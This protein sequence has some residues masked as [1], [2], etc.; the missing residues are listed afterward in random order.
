M[1]ILVVALKHRPFQKVA[2][3]QPILRIANSTDVS[4]LNTAASSYR[5]ISISQRLRSSASEWL[6]ES[7]SQ[8]PIR[9]T[10][11]SVTL[12]GAPVIELG[13][14]RPLPLSGVIAYGRK[15]HRKR[16]LVGLR[17]AGI[18]P[19]AQLRGVHLTAGPFMLQLLEYKARGGI[20]LDLHITMSAVRISPS[21]CLTSRLNT[22]SLY[23]QRAM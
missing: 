7:L 12:I 19:G 15:L 6:V 16:L 2:F 10:S 22:W 20:A 3:D 17:D 23:K 21:M 1:H 4:P 9:S 14:N 8:I 11:P 18:E 13:G 5:I